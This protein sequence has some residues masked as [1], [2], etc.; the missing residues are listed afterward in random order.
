[1]DWTVTATESGMKLL[2]FLQSKVP[3]N[4]SARHLK[5]T[6]EQN[7]CLVN[8]RTERFASHVLGSGDHVS[9]LSTDVAKTPSITFEPS[10]VLYEDNDIFLYDKPPHVVS[11]DPAFHKVLQRKLPF[12]ELTHRLDRDTTGALLFAKTPKAYESL[13]NQFREREIKKCYLAIVDGVLNQSTGVIENY[14]GPV[15]QYQGQTL[16]GTVSKA[17]GQHAI[18]EWELIQKAKNVSLVRCYPKTGRTH[19]LRVHLNSIGHPI[20]GD[21]QYC[22]SFLCPYRPE[23]ILLH[24]E[25]LSLNHPVTKNPIHISAPTPTDFSEAIQKLFGGHK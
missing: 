10:R 12:L 19:Q 4:L 16:W 3:S 15:H 2:A 8:N 14:L 11:N 1:M 25:S 22:R 18:T 17:K 7:L 9:L 21:Y 24:A 20:L 6:I 23:R 13:L 5:R